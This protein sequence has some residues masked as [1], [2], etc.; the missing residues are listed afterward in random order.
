MKALTICQP[1]AWLIVHGPK[2]YENRQWQ[3]SYRGPLL[4]HAGKSRHCIKEN[5]LE[6]WRA[7]G[8]VI[9]VASDLPFG[10]VVGICRLADCL[11]IGRL[12][13]E[14]ASGPWCWRL[15]NVRAFEQPIPCRGGLRLFDLPD[16]LV[17]NGQTA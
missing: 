1:W 5:A 2:R 12:D 14:W 11:P 13:D 3:T 16:E 17:R 8:L 4:I 9:P 15:E 7:Q 6:R 10:A